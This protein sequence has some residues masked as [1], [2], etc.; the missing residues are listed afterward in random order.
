MKY[1]LFLYKKNQKKRKNKP[2]KL[3]KKN[4]PILK[5]IFNIYNIYNQNI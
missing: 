4:R 1:I 3:I 2:K 5:T